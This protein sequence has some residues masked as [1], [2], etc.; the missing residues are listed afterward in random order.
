M[1]ARIFFFG[2]CLVV[3]SLAGCGE[4]VVV[5]DAAMLPDT[6]R[7][8]G[9]AAPPDAPA[10]HPPVA[11]DDAIGARAGIP[12]DIDVLA[13]DTD[14]DGDPLSVIAA[15]SAA[16]G[17]TSASATRVTY[18]AALD[19]TGTD[20]LTYVVGD[21]HGGLDTG[22]VH[23]TLLTQPNT[24]PVAVDDVADTSAGV[25]VTIMVLANDTD[26]DGDALSVARV[27]TPAHGTASTDGSVVTYTPDPGTTGTDTFAYDVEDPSAA[28][29]SAT[30]TITVHAGPQAVDDAVITTPDTSIRIAVLANDV[31]P[32]G[33]PI[34]LAAT[35]TPAH[36]TATIDTG[37]IVYVPEAGFRGSDAFTYTISDVHGGTDSGAVGVAVSAAL[38][39]GRLAVAGGPT[40]AIRDDAALVSWGSGASDLPTQVGASTDWMRVATGGGHHCAID[41]M[42]ALFCWGDG[43]DGKLGLGADRS[44]RVSPTQVGSETGWVDVSLGAFHT[45]GIRAGAL[46]CW[47]EGD[48]GKLGLGDEGSR[49]VPTQVGSATDWTAVTAGG[50]HTCGIRAGQLWCW[51]WNATSAL[52]SPTLPTST[53]TLAPARIGVDTDWAVVR[54][55]DYHTCGLRLDGSLWCWG[56]VPGTGTEP[57]S[58]TRVG[59]SH[60]WSALDA[61]DR[62]TCGV[63]AGGLYCWGENGFGQL[64]DGTQITRA[65]PTRIGSASDWVEAGIGGTHACAM[66]A[67]GAVSCWGARASHLGDGVVLGA[68]VPTRVGTRTDWARVMSGGADYTCASTMDGALW[69]WGITP[70]FGGGA[71]PVPRAEPTQL[72]TQLGWSV[73]P[74]GGNNHLCAIRADGGL[75]CWGSG[76]YGRLGV[77]SLSSFGLPQPVGGTTTF[78]D[79]APGD[80]HTCA[81]TSAGHLQCWGYNNAGTLG[82]PSVSQTWVPIEVGTDTT[83][84][85]VGSGYWG[86]CATRTDGTLWCWGSGTGTAPTRIGTASDWR[87]VEAQ[88]TQTCAITTSGALHCGSFTSLTRVGLDSDW[89]KVSISGAIHTCGVR[90]SG[91][92]WCFGAND[93]GQLGDGTSVGRTLPTRVGTGVDWADVAAGGGPS[94]GH[95]CA[96]RTDGTLWCWGDDRSGQLGLGLAFALAPVAITL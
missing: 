20:E 84:S 60:G 23:V 16:H 50:A 87:S 86:S 62:S 69:C 35:S 68:S 15:S 52:G 66:R 89:A 67:G 57:S 96:I 81:V 38:A 71:A 10:G 48:S 43:R 6:G 59:T 63:D 47:G 30:I 28:P 74:Q 25:P 36:G 75:W 3:L 21:G 45:C 33:L 85:D 70:W 93:E 51:G 32:E 37:E 8:A 27:A 94:S 9:D 42:G 24:P 41:T 34:T 56:R 26:P 61:G 5:P 76:V 90:T 29:A 95:T 1:R 11:V 13:N 7:V 64:G 77:G 12:I 92:L 46:F 4:P 78:R 55:G 31:H 79:V 82:S 91:S 88:R 40:F 65:A 18:T 58:P 22:T 44:D 72:G 73:L 39:S 83:W 53:P 19:A 80:L 14:A 54:A 49:D 2:A 17:T